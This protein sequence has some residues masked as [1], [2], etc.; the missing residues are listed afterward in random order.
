MQAN[1]ASKPIRQAKRDFERNI[2]R[3]IK[4]D[5]FYTYTKSKSKMKPSVGPLIDGSGTVVSNDK[6]MSELLNGFFS[7]VFTKEKTDCLPEIRQ[8]FKVV[9]MTNYDVT[10][11]LQIWTRVNEAPGADSINT[12]MLLEL[13]EDISEILAVIFNKSLLSGE[14]N[15]V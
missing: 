11:L 1:K 2:A 3:N 10:V 9:T 14:V 8:I 13:S 15:H 6:E 12:R 7:S 5:S 4:H